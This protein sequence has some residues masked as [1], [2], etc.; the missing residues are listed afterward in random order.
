MCYTIHIYYCFKYHVNR[1]TKKYWLYH[2]NILKLTSYSLVKQYL[3]FIW[4]GS[5]K[6]HL[7]LEWTK[8]FLLLQYELQ[9]E[10]RSFRK[11][12]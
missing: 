4:L 8:G 12:I 5:V 1:S 6:V 10:L 9:I 11:R 2:A 7:I 3:C